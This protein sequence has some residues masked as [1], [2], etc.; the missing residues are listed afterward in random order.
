MKKIEIKSEAD[1]HLDVES[2]S[3]SGFYRIPDHVYHKGPGISQSSLKAFSEDPMKYNAE[4]LEPKK[5]KALKDGTAFDLLITDPGSICYLDN[6]NII[7]PEKAPYAEMYVLPPEFPTLK[8]KGLTDWLRARYLIEAKKAGKILTHSDLLKFTS[9]AISLAEHPVYS[10]KTNGEGFDTEYCQVSAYWTDSN[11]VLRRCRIDYLDP[12]GT[13]AIDI[14]KTR[15]VSNKG[16][17][18]TNKDFRYY[19]QDGWYSKILRELLPKFEC[20]YFFAVLD[21]VPY[22][23]RVFQFTLEDQAIGLMQLET[24]IESFLLSEEK[25]V[26]VSPYLESVEEISLPNWA[27]H[28]KYEEY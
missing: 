19:C 11:G 21:V 24:N 18:K 15:D 5:T 4:K 7:K 23:T 22:H 25:Q 16:W 26:F 27:K 2:G 14:K 20:F 3:V 13:F 28:V 9:M 8:E 10:E 17:I 6:L 1:F 12:Y